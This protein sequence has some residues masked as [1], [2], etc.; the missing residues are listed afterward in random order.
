MH[1]IKQ[2]ARKEGGG[3][4]FHSFLHGGVLLRE[5]EAAE[6]SEVEREM[7]ADGPSC[8]IRGIKKNL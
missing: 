5:V 3:E 7:D 8:S 1:P 2:I 4:I 6:T